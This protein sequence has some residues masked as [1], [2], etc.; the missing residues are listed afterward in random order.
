[1]RHDAAVSLEDITAH[2]VLRGPVLG[3][4]VEWNGDGSIDVYNASEEVAF[5]VEAPPGEAP[6]LCP[7][8]EI[9]D[10]TATYH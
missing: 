5:H 9:C 7:G 8:C 6:W 2:G 4:R 3:A 10:G 1:M